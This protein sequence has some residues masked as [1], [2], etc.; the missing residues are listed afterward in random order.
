M[1]ALLLTLAALACP[2]P[3]QGAV[4][5]SL[6]RY[7]V[8]GAPTPVRGRR[9]REEAAQALVACG[10]PDASRALLEWRRQRRAVNVS[11]AVAVGVAWPVAVATVVHGVRAN[12]ERRAFLDALQEGR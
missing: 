12:R 2:D 10:M 7:T 8:A 9:A 6:T 3:T 5:A 1:L 4:T 11:A